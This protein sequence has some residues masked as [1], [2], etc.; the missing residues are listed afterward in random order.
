MQRHFELASSRLCGVYLVKQVHDVLK[1]RQLQRFEA[2][3]SSENPD[4]CFSQ[5]LLLVKTTSC[6]IFGVCGIPFHLNKPLWISEPCND[7]PQKLVKLL[8]QVSLRVKLG[9]FQMCSHKVSKKL[10]QLHNDP[11]L[12]AV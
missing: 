12:A 8:I 4:L 5:C 11:W 10:I 1:Q 2:A 3:Q 7:N 9:K 6:K